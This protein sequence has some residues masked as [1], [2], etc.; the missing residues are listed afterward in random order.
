MACLF[1]HKWNGCKCSRCG[2][3]RDEQHNWNV[4]KCTICGKEAHT[5]S[6]YKCSRCGKVDL[7]AIGAINI[8]TVNQMEDLAILLK[9]AKDYLVTPIRSAAIQRRTHLISN[10]TD[11]DALVSIVY[12]DEESVYDSRYS[13]RTDFRE[14]AVNS[15]SDQGLRAKIAQDH[16]NGGIRFGAVTNLK[17]QDALKKVFLYDKESKVRQAALHRLTDQ[18]YLA[19]IAKTDADPTLRKIAVTMLS[20]QAVIEE[21]AS[22]DKDRNV[23]LA[24]IE[25]LDDQSYLVEIAKNDNDSMV[26]M[27]ALK[28]I[29]DSD[30]ILSIARQAAND[31]VKQE[32]MKKLGGYFCYSCQSENLPENGQPLACACKSC[33]AENHDFEKMYK[34]TSLPGHAERNESWEMCVRCNLTRNH[35]EDIRY[36][37]W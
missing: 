11:N 31:S 14:I 35:S 1:G 3:T 2:K 26:N 29:T 37:D 30:M 13:I 19:E 33:N 25:K 34:T 36:T 5:Y 22:S 24:A 21:I 6:N 8:E 7:S 32:A 17:D 28:K 20:G 18:S 4:C 16:K 23:R 12:S 27:A 15:I 9:I 10:M